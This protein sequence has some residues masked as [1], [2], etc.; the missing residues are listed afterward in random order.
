M[1]QKLLVTLFAAVVLV[2]LI[3]GIMTL[4]HN[5]A[6]KTEESSLIVSGTEILIVPSAMPERISMDVDPSFTETKSE[7]YDKYYVCNDASVIVT[8]ETLNIYGQNVR[9]YG[10]SVLQQY[11]AS[12]DGF[13]LLSDETVP[14]AKTDC[15][16]LEFTYSI[17]SEDAEQKMQCTTAILIKD[18]RVYIVTCKSHMENYALYRQTFRRMI[19]SIQ[20]ADEPAATASA[21]TE[22]AAETAPPVLMQ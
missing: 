5:R 20:I 10:D 4:T 18:E 11:S 15:R 2:M 8:G 13:T 1:S 12:A 7:S 3:L 9:D 22:T 14:V 19:E 21:G 17:R 16:V 6:D